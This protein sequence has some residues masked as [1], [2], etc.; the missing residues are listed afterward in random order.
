MLNSYV[1]LLLILSNVIVFFM[2]R[3]DKTDV[4]ELTMS[5]HSVFTLREYIRILT[6]GFAHYDPMHLLM[7]MLSLYN[8]GTFVESCF[9]HFGMLLI[10]FG[11]LVLGK[12]ASLYL[13]HYNHD[14]YSSSLGASGAT[15]WWSFATMASRALNICFVRSSPWCS[16]HRS[17]GWM[18][19]PTSAAWRW[20][21]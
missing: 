6:S 3:T 14:D 20:G 5:Y 11:S 8:V 15:S 9:G 19:R 10:Y 17:R 21:S 16:S 1:T 4:D 12:L 13:R 2:I 7:N 18:A